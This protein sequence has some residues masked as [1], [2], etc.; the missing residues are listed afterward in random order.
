MHELSIIQSL[1]DRVE[2][3]VLK[4]GARSVK[5]L[6]VRVGELSGVEPELLSL[7]WEAFR[8]AGVCAGASLSIEV[9]ATRWSCPRCSLDVPPG[10]RLRC[11]VC[12]VPATLAEGGEII[13]Q[14][15]ELEVPDV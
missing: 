9:V 11:R 10:T 6:E 12:D 15:V 2:Q 3:E 7:A 4:A 1:V 14:R 5:R 8:E 13:L